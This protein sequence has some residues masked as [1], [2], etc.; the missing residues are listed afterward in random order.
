MLLEQGIA[1]FGGQTHATSQGGFSCDSGAAL[2]LP[3]SL[4][5]RSN[6]RNGLSKHQS[7]G[8]EVRLFRMCPGKGTKCFLNP[9]RHGD[10]CP[11][12]FDGASVLEQ[13]QE[14]GRLG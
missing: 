14:G 1:L 12:F 4:T 8:D 11:N 5:S 9:R 10:Q 13:W 7:P 2:C 6:S 3:S